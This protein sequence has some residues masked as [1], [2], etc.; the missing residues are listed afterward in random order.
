[1]VEAIEVQVTEELA[2]QV[3]DRQ[4]PAPL[5]GRKQVVAGREWRDVEFVKKSAVGISRDRRTRDSSPGLPKRS[6][7]KAGCTHPPARQGFV[8]VAGGL[9]LRAGADAPKQFLHK[10]V[11]LV[12]KLLSRLPRERL[13]RAIVSGVR[14]I[15]TLP[16]S[17]SC[18]RERL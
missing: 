10:L 18:W 13:N 1:M 6:R 9:S 16:R 15:P 7:L 5:E 4:A 14:Y 3:A 2:G 17:A 11:E 8:W 12:K